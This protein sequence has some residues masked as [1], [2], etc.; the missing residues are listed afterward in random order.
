M[1][2]RATRALAGIPLAIILST[3]LAVG[4]L[5]NPSPTEA[6]PSYGTI[7][8]NVI[9]I[10]S[11][12]TYYYN[13]PSSTDY[14][15]DTLCNEW[16]CSW[17][18]HALYAGAVSIRSAAFWEMSRRWDTTKNCHARLV[19]GGYYDTQSSYIDGETDQRYVHGSAVD[20]YGSRPLSIVGGVPDWHGHY[21][22]GSSTDYI[23]TAYG[24]TI[25]NE[26]ETLASPGKSW[27]QIVHQIY[28]N[29]NTG[30]C[31]DYHTLSPTI[32]LSQS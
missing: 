8:I 3:L 6:N 13:P 25:Q 16:L 24:S 7:T 17:H 27:D 30:T 21:S 14:V 31:S 15:A 29:A 20:R 19:N 26:T 18:D 2:R 5:A 22:S 9:E 10:E 4:D 32:V 28:D 11:S 1:K 12:G 23:Y